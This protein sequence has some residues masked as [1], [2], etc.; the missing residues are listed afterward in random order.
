MG[1]GTVK[2]KDVKH[3]LNLK[4]YNSTKI[5]MK[6]LKMLFLKLTTLL[7]NKSPNDLHCFSSEHHPKIKHIQFSQ[8]TQMYL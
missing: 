5:S 3:S 1:L 6:R 4:N 7:S 2:N 8:I